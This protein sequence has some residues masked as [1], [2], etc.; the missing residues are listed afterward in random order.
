MRQFLSKS[1]YFHFSI[2]L[3]AIKTKDLENHLGP[4]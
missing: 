4:Q 3:F 1:F 2:F